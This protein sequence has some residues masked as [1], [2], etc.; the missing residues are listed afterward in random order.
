V[1]KNK[2]MINGAPRPQEGASAVIVGSG[3]QERR[4][5]CRW[6]FGKTGDFVRKC[7][8]VGLQVRSP[9]RPKATSPIRNL[10]VHKALVLIVV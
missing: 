7:L 8:A 6:N 9:N 10:G 4:Q 1:G 5:A 3:W 2:Q